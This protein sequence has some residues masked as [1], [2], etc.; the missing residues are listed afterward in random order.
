MKEITKTYNIPLFTT[1]ELRKK[2]SNEDKNKKRSLHDIME[3]GKYAYNADVVWML[4]PEDYEKY[5]QESEPTIILKFEKN[6]LASFRGS[7]ELKFKRAISTFE[8]LQ[9]VNSFTSQLLGGIKP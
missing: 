3:T 2:Q 4:S 1:A 8:E 6:K 7:M 9:S 5:D